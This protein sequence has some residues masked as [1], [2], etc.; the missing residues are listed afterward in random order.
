MC[1]NNINFQ[2]WSREHKAQGQGQ[3]YKKIRDQGQRQPFRGQTLLRPRT[4]MF[5]AKDKGASAL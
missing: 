4:G 3:E 2:R 5:E 1:L